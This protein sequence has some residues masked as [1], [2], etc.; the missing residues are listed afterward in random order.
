VSPSDQPP[1]LLLN[2]R[3]VAELGADLAPLGIPAD[4]A[5]RLFA[6]VHGRGAG[7]E[8]DPRRVRGLGK[9]HLAALSAAGARAGRVEI[10]ARRRSPADGFVKYLFRLEGGALVEAVCIPLP[11]GPDTTPEKHILCI[12]SQA[13]CPLA[14]AFCATGRMGLIRNLAAWEILEQVAR[15]RDEVA[16][17]IRGVV[18]MG[19]GEPFL[20]YDAVIRAA[21]VLSDPAAFA[22]AA[23]AITISTAGIVPAIRRYTAEGH[24]YR[25]AISLTSAIEDKR[26]R[27]MPIE[28]RWPLEELLDAARA[29]A[30]A[31]RGRVMLEYVTIAGVN[32]GEDDARALV[33]RLAGLPIRLN[34]IDVNDATGRF[35]PPT[36]ADLSRFRD[37]LQPLGQPIVRR[38]SGGKDVEAAC[39]ML[40]AT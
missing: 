13:G 12:S 40:A 14:C 18:F 9:A 2:D 7:A 16:R 10:A 1:S 36:A 39:G 22:I 20:N 5:R 19:M 30:R 34:L 35:A 31:T 8:P 11:A 37:W 28:K 23:K 32:V 33:T 15:I 25:L 3:T 17:P 4:V 21:R 38:Y 24:K 29:H 27:L 6:R 26:R